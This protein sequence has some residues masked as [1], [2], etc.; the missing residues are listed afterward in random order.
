M[1]TGSSSAD[2]QPQVK[3]STCGGVYSAH[4]DWQ[5]GRCPHHPSML[6]QIL[7]D[8]YRSRFYNLF[9]WLRK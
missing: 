4:C 5:Q 1:G 6:D 2:T 8:N 7:A 9:N 3:C